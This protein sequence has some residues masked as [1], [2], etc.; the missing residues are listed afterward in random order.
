MTTK[1]NFPIPE[2]A[3]KSQKLSV[4][5]KENRQELEPFTTGGEIDGFFHN[6]YLFD[7]MQVEQREIDVKKETLTTK[8]NGIYNK[9]M[10]DNA[11]IRS[12]IYYFPYASSEMKRA[13][14]IGKN[15]S[16]THM[17]I[18]KDAMVC[19][20]AFYE[21][22]EQ[23]NFAGITEE[24]INVKKGML[25]EIEQYNEEQ[26][27]LEN[28]KVKMTARKGNVQTELGIGIR[29]FSHLGETIFKD[30]NPALSEAFVRIRQMPVTNS[31]KKKNDENKEDDKNPKMGVA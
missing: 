11:K 24:R 10:E 14:G 3:E 12:A 5:L 26:M 16:T 18:R 19:I 1:A 15:K 28:E 2:T 4:M 21:F 23:S 30:S 6:T 17:E 22:K 13:Y 31:K 7:Q 25:K 8:K 9:I 29:R 20:N 27:Q